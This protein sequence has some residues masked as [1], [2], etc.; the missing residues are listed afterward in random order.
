MKKI[1]FLLALTLMAGVVN[2]KTDKLY[3]TLAAENSG[4][5]S[6]NVF[7]WTSAP[8]TGGGQR[9]KLFSSMKGNVDL[10]KYKYLHVKISDK[11]GGAGWRFVI[12][13]N[14]NA[15]TEAYH[16]ASYGSTMEVRVDLTSL[17]LNDGSERTLAE[18]NGIYVQGAYT[19]GNFTI[20][21]EDCYLETDEYECMG[22]TSTLNSSSTDTTPFTWVFNNGKSLAHKNFGKNIDAGSVLWGYASDNSVANGYFDVTGYD[23][24][25]P[26]ITT[27]TGIL[28]YLN[29]G[30]AIE[31][32]GTANISNINKITSIKTKNAAITVAAI[33]FVKEF[34]PA[35]ITAFSI[36][37]SSSSTVNYDRTFTIGRKC[38][39]CLPFALNATE[40]DAAGK[41]YELSSV[42]GGALHFTEVNETEA[43]KPYVFEPSTATPFSSLTDKAIAATPADAS[44]Y[45]TTVD[46]YTFQGT[47]AHQNVPNGAYGYNAAT[48]AFS[49][50]TS[51]A[52]TINAFRAYITVSGGSSA[53]A[54]TCFFGDMTTGIKTINTTEKGN[55]TIYNLAG[56][57]VTANHKGLVIKNGRKVVIK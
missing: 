40:V 5:Y 37:A 14:N 54:L 2:A 4:T 30:S 26:T 35:S 56:Q 3:A 21:A 42:A 34:Q 6:E 43:Y 36:T 18:V 31:T 47:L 48:G 13:C 52:V 27:G 24:A 25:V 23:K 15:N 20:L 1:L 9:L 50:A 12:M 45:A 8:S 53:P 10:T 33:D 16:S 55:E 49:K 17:T 57:R 38:T 46:G 7:T 22:I 32:S 41:F 28:R 39:V 44:D 19:A 11:S 29:E 51:D